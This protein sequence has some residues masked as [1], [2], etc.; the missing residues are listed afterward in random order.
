DWSIKVIPEVGHHPI[1]ITHTADGKYTYVIE[2]HASE[3]YKIDNATNKV[4][5]RT[6]AGVAGPYGIALNWD[7]TL[8]YTV[9]KGEGSHNQGGVL[10]V[11]DTKRFRQTSPVHE[12][13]IWL[14]GSASSVDHAILHPDPAVNE[15]WISNMNGWETIVLD[16]KTNKP[17]A[18]IPTPNGGNTHSGGFIRY[19]PDWSGEWLLDQGGPKSKSIWDLVKAKV[20]A[21]SK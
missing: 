5:D 3:V 17:K 10:G 20:A 18:Y 19:N 15:L 6:S 16:L 8:L 14:G 12:M 2:A 11:I 7:E 9:G 21:L 13:P 4:V 1:G